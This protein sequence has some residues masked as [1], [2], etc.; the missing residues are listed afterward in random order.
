[1][2][3]IRD[4]KD[5]FFLRLVLTFKYN[6]KKKYDTINPT[7]AIYV[8]NGQRCLPGQVLSSHVTSMLV[9]FPLA[10][11]KYIIKGFILAESSRVQFTVVRKSW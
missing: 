1:M 2:R 10:V 6:I 7:F 11:M 9:S 3:S 5:T 8:I 4:C